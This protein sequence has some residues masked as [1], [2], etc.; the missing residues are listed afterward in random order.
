MSRTE[1]REYVVGILTAGILSAILVLAAFANRQ[2]V[3]LDDGFL[4]LTA[5]F[6]RADGIYVGS[7]VRVAGLDVGTISNMALD[8]HN[9]VILTLQFDNQVLL[10]EDTAAVIETDGIFGSKYLE[11]YAGGAEEILE[12]GG[13]ISYTQDSVILEDL[14]ALIVDRARA[15]S[16]T[17]AASD[18]AKE[19]IDLENEQK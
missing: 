10:P 12:P 17:N 13:H 14:I 19:S 1:R 5:D 11:L 2:L 4:R 8:E 16:R 9:K 3:S 6:E 7:P 18:L 15:A